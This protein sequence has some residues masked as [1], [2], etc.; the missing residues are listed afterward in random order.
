MVW[1]KLRDAI[2]DKLAMRMRA[3]SC[4]ISIPAFVSFNDHDI[5][6]FADNVSPPW[7]LKTRSEPQR[8]VL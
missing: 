7:V 3:K 2:S 8:Q 1:D 5:N 6:T 4:G